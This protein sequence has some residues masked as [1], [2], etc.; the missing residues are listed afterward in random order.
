MPRS[1]VLRVFSL[2]LV[3]LAISFSNPLHLFPLLNYI[4][5]LIAACSVVAGVAWLMWC[6]R[7]YRFSLGSALW[8]ALGGLFLASALIQP[9]TFASGKLA[10]LLYWFIGALALIVGEQL[11][12]SDWRTADRLAW[13]LFVCAVFGAVMGGLRHF[14]LLWSGFDAL[15]PKVQSERM[16]G[17]IGQSN[18]FGFLCLMGGLSGAWL[19]HRRAINTLALVVGMGLCICGLLMSGSR[20]AL[21]GWFCLVVLL[22]LRGQAWGRY[23]IVLTCGLLSTL[24]LM[25]AMPG[26]LQWLAQFVPEGVLDGRMQAIGQRGIDSPARLTEWKIAFDVWKENP[27]FGVG[28]G[29]YSHAAFTEHVAQG[30]SSGAGLFTHSHNVFLQLLV[31]LGV[32]G[33]IWCLAFGAFFCFSAWRALKWEQNLLPISVL[34]IFA[35]YSLFEFPLWIMTFLILNLLLMGSLP[36]PGIT[37]RLRL[38]KLFSAVL[39]FVLFVMVAVYVPLVE[40][41]Y[42]SF[43]QYLVRAPVKIEEYNFMS[44]MMKDPLMESTGY[45]IYFANF[46]VSKKTAVQEREVLERFQRYVPYPPLMA[47]LAILQVATG[48]ADAGKRTVQ[49]SRVYYGSSG[50]EAFIYNSLDEAKAAFPEVDFSVLFQK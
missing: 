26:L 17:L 25:P 43:I 20:S 45:I 41:F 39:G 15:V 4:E 6:H 28:I 3:M 21:L 49:E 18:Y 22:W 5:E 8:L 23:C 10:Y 29:N 36:G 13:V 2:V 24:V 47:R 46:Q 35:I 38:S 44:A 34:L 40:R 50:I 37:L 33:G 11:D 9:A 42:W 12:W 19:Y 31:E 48:D 30:V 32:L 14:G 16:I 7:E 27:W 1:N